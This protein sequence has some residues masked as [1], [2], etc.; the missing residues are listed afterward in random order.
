MNPAEL[1]ATLDATL[2]RISR[3]VPENKASWDADD[4]RQLAIERLWI[5]AGNVAEAYR[6]AT[7]LPSGVEPWAELYGYRSILAHALPDEIAPD[8][9]WHETV[10]DLPRI[11]EQVRAARE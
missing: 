10:A 1:I 9:I 2:V 6:T 5:T 7:G 3:L 8:R 11:L 4:L